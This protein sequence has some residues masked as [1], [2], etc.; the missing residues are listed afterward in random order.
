M[1]KQILTI[2]MMS[3]VVFSFAETYKG[4]VKDPQD[5]AVPF[6]NVVLFSL[7][8]STFVEGTTTNDLG[9]FLLESKKVVK[10]YLEISSIGYETKKV[11][12][13]EDVG[14][15]ILQEETTELGEVVVKA[16]LP[17]MQVKDD[18]F[19]TTVQNS[20]LAKAGSANNVLQRLPML[21]G[22]DGDYT[23]FGKGKAKIYINNRE[24]RDAS[25]LENLNSD[26]IK[27][28]E[29]VTNPGAR[30]DASVKAV[31]RIY[32]VKRVGDGFSFDARSTYYQSKENAD[33][34]E[35]LN[36]NYRKKGWDIFGT[37]YYKN[38]NSVENDDLEQITY[39]V[40]T[41]WRQTGNA[42]FLNRSKYL[43][44]ITG[45]NYEFSP[46][47][48][49]GIKYSY[50]KAIPQED[51]KFL[52]NVIYANGQLY[53]KWTTSGIDREEGLPKHIV[54]AYYNGSLGK[55]EIN[56]DATYFTKKENTNTTTS[57]KSQTFENRT[58]KTQ[59]NLDN[60]MFASK[61]VLTYPVFKGKLSFGNEYTNTNRDDAYWANQ[62]TPSS[63]TRI[64]QMSNS[65]FAEYRRSCSLGQFTA[66]L[67]YENIQSD[68]FV[69][70]VFKKEQSKDF[71]QW[72]PSLSFSTKVKNVG[73]QLSYTSKT[74]RPYYNQLSNN[75]SYINRFTLK[76]G[77]PFLRPTITHDVTLAGSWKFFQLMLSYNYKKDVILQSVEQM[78]NNSSTVILTSKNFDKLPQ[79]SA[80]LSMSPTIG[81]WSPQ[82]SVG[83]LKQWFELENNNSFIR[84]NKPIFSASFNNSFQFPKAFLFTLDTSYKGKGNAENMYGAKGAFLVNT[85]L[86]K[87]FLDNTLS[88]SVKGYDIFNSH[89]M[90]AF[91]YNGG[92]DWYLSQTRDT[93]EI[94][95]TI[96]YKFNTARSK[97]KGKGAGNSEINRM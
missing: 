93:Q 18:A 64:E 22:K 24:M 23:V 33:W 68:Y 80:F 15:I 86:T 87:T 14:T 12:A 75:T 4:T 46:Q 9:Q 53:D 56:F 16:Q 30:Y 88:V 71:R 69:D 26:D 70:E 48:Y 19:V 72:F 42:K 91:L 41:V 61:L 95:L 76:S 44:L 50:G 29:I 31:I 73:L 45:V 66:G 36:M 2:L 96:R 34:V 92:A 82:L 47:H 49:A 37:A 62:I 74:T 59:N 65:F 21:T 58:I 94:S 8:D 1:K 97:Y 35:K 38:I 27:S 60:S 54:N 10:G 6:A 20:V 32:T 3:M 77:N 39:C 84:L 28:V 13:K 57:E 25:E 81:I 89:K 90:N 5:K 7:P 17:K 43:G 40:D 51:E 52:D 63:T 83:V 11:A 55:L 85:G 78:E 79:F 67:R